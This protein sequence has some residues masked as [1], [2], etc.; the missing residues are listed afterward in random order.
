MPVRYLSAERALEAA[1]AAFA[2][3][4]DEGFTGSAKATATWPRRLRI[5]LLSIL[6]LGLI[7]A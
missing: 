4:D 1:G 5:T 3:A 2:F 6:S 7:V